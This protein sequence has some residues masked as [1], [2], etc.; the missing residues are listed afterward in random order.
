MDKR[1]RDGGVVKLLI[2]NQK[3]HYIRNK[4][5]KKQ[6]HTMLTEIRFPLM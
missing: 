3:T 5:N 6:N 1:K 4:V 2:K